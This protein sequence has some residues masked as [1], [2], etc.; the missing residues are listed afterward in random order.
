MNE[1]MNENMIKVVSNK[2]WCYITF[3]SLYLG[4]C[5]T[6]FINSITISS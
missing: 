1:W 3:K 5:L 2:V 4:T 6:F